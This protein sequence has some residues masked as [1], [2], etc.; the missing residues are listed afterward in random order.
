AYT[1]QGNYV[2]AI[3]QLQKAFAIFEVLRDKNKMAIALSDIGEVYFQLNNYNLS[4]EH[5]QKSLKLFEELNSLA[6]SSMRIYAIGNVHF[7]TGNFDL[8]IESYQKA[9]GQF[10]AIKHQ[11][12][13]ASMLASIAGTLYA[14]QKYDLAL[15]FYQK[16]L[17]IYESLN[18]RSRA[19][20]VI[21]RIASVYYSK[22]DYPQSLEVAARAVSLAEQ[23][24]SLDTLWRARLTQ[25]LAFRALNRNEDAQQSFTQSIGAIDLMRSRLVRGE[26]EAQQFFRAKNAAYL[27]MME[28]LIAQNR[29]AEALGYA[30]RVRTNTLLD[31]LQ[32]AQINKAMSGP[33]QEQE[34]LAQSSAL[35]VKAQ[36]SHERERKRPDEQRLHVLEERLQ[37][38]L[39]DYRGYENRIYAAHPGLKALRGEADPLR[40]DDASTVVADSSTALLQFAVADARTYLFVLTRGGAAKRSPAGRAQ[41]PTYLLNAY[42]IDIARG[43]LADRVEKF[44]ELIKQR[45][46]SV[47]QTG[48]ELYDLLLAPATGQLAGKSVLLIV[49]D[50]ALWRLPFEALQTAGDRYLIEDHAI[51]YATSLTGLA[52]MSKPVASEKGVRPLTAALFANPAISKQTI[53]R[54][55]LASREIVVPSPDAESE[56]K[57][58]ER[59]YG[60]AKCKVYIGAHA[61]EEAAKQESGKWRVIHFAAPAR[62]LDASP[63]YSRVLL[64]QSEENGSEDGLLEA[65][66]L[67]KLDLKADIV[68]FSASETG[69]EKTGTGDGISALG[70]SLYVAG[71][72]TNMLSRWRTDAAASNTL[73]TEFHR[74]LQSAS[75]KSKSRALQL[76]TLKMLRETQNRH[77]FYWAGFILVGSTR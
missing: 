56:V 4:L 3:E 29:V 25:G 10:E 36:I 53:D 68:V 8:A 48:R 73:M 16:S 43:Q 11:P 46:E 65:W 64:S 22:S 17:S 20:G 21:E 28:L 35:A 70:W 57:S 49:P 52:E 66:E 27:A 18:D 42:V 15:D 5:Y 44:Q 12:G 77:P 38:A 32:R 34:R 6:D 62:L 24:S 47:Q 50:D 26:R 23:A 54:V 67:M 30:D 61:S 37:R 75:R 60:A 59:V 31:I 41:P 7:V 51:S 9:L 55:M 45:K 71:C 13:V 58:L 63:L 40:L 19:A 76:A 72:P 1:W 69:G 2:P 74:E 33:E 14:Q 39:R